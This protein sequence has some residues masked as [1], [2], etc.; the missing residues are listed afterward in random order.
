MKDKL[1]QVFV[2]SGVYFI[3][4]AFLGLISQHFNLLAALV[5]PV[6]LFSLL[7]LTFFKP[8]NWVMK[9]EDNFP[10]VVLL[11]NIF[12]IYAIIYFTVNVLGMSLSYITGKDTVISIFYQ[13][14][15]EVINTGIDLVFYFGL[16]VALLLILVRKFREA[17]NKKTQKL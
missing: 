9:F 17:V 2:L 1:M 14:W 8:L 7:F 13:E 10:S 12:G 16:I 5:F 6:F 11:L 15:G 4:S 3:I